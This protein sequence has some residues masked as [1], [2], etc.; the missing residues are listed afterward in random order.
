MMKLK[1]TFSYISALTISLITALFPLP[2]NA[3]RHHMRS[4]VERDTVALFRGIA[5]SVDAVGAIQRW[6]SDYGQYEGAL[7]LNLKDRYF[8]TIEF[9][10]GDADHDDE[11]TG[12]HYT[13]KAPYGR[14]G[15]DFNLLKDKHDIYRLYLGA[16][17]GYTSFKYSIDSPGIEDPLWQTH[18]EYSMKDIQCKYHWAE[19]VAGVQAKIAGPLHL[20]W[21]VR[22]RSR[23]SQKHGDAGEPWYVPGFGKSGSSRLG[24]IFNIILEL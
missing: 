5:V 18:S 16:R 1:K 13:S 11:V 7:K 8:P 24:A 15:I 9:G 12:I 17:Y 14:I 2:A 22:Y 23:L 21:S 6:V 19:A 3:Q 20:G 10:Y 4:T